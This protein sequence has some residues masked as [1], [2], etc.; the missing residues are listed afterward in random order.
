MRKILPDMKNRFIIYIVI[1][2]QL[3]LCAS[4]A[5]AQD[6]QAPN[7]GWPVRT[8]ESADHRGR[9]AG[10]PSEYRAPYSNGANVFG[11]AVANTVHRYHAGVDITSDN[12][13]N[14]DVYSIEE[15]DHIVD[16][17]SAGYNSRILINNVIY[18]HV[19]H[20]SSILDGI[21]EV[22]YNDQIGDMNSRAAHL[23][24]QP[25]LPE[26]DG[27]SN[28]LIDRLPNY[29]D[30][31]QPEI[32]NAYFYSNG[33]TKTT[34]SFRQNDQVNY[35]N[36]THTI[37]YDK[38]DLVISTNEERVG[39]NGRDYAQG[40]GNMG[41]NQL[42]YEI[43]NEY[44]T[45]ET[46]GFVT[47]LD[48]STL[49]SHFSAQ[50]IFGHASTSAQ[51]Y[52]VLTSFVT[53]DEEN[54]PDRFWNSRLRSGQTE[55][56]NLMN[57]E[58]KEA[59]VNLETRYSDGKYNVRFRVRDVDSD[60]ADN[61]LWSNYREE[62]IIIDNF[63]PFIQKVS[64]YSSQN[65]VFYDQ[66]WNWDNSGGTLDFGHNEGNGEIPNVGE[67]IEFAIVTSEPMSEVNISIPSLGV[68][69]VPAT[70]LGLAL[71]NRHWSF[72]LYGNITETGIHEIQITG[73]DYANNELQMDPSQ[74]P[75]RNANGTWSAG[76]APGADTNHS[77]EFFDGTCNTPAG[78]RTNGNCPL[79]ADFIHQMSTNSPLT[80]IFSSLSSPSNEISSW[81]W[82][83]GDGNSSSD[84]NPTHSY[85]SEGTFLVRL[86]V[87][88]GSE[89]DSYSKNITISNDLNPVFSYTP[90]S[91]N[92]PLFVDLNSSASTGIITDRSWI[93]TPSNGWRYD[94][95]NQ[96]SVSPRLEF[97]N[98]GTYRV[99]LRIGDGHEV[100]D[101]PEEII[102]VQTGLDPVANF[103]WNAP[104]YVNGP[105]RF[106]DRSLFPCVSSLNY[107][108]DFGDGQTSSIG[109]PE[110]I[111]SSDGDYNVTLC[112]EDGCGS[113]DCITKTVHVDPVPNLFPRFN[114]NTYTIRK[115][116]SITF[117]DESTPYSNIGAW[118]WWFEE[119]AD[120][121]GRA[122]GAAD[123][124]YGKSG[125]SS[126][127]THQYNK[128]GEYKVALEVAVND[129]VQGP[130]TSAIIKVIDDPEIPYSQKITSQFI[131]KNIKD[132]K[133][134]GDYTAVLAQDNIGPDY[135]NFVFIYKQVGNSLSKVAEIRDQSISDIA[136][137]GETLVTANLFF[138]NKKIAIWEKGAGEW[139]NMTNPT[140]L[141][142]E[143][144]FGNRSSLDIDVSD[145]NVIALT[146]DNNAFI[147]NKNQS[148]GWPVSHSQKIELA[149]GLVGGGVDIAI[150]GNTIIA[151]SN[152]YIN[153][154]RN[155]N[156]WS[157]AATIEPI[158]GNGRWSS[159][160]IL[161]NTFV[162]L[163]SS[164]VN[165]DVFNNP[166]AYVWER[167][168][169]GD[170]QSNQSPN[171]ELGIHLDSDI[172]QTLNGFGNGTV[173]INN[174]NITIS[175]DFKRQG[176]PSAIF[177]Y[178]R[179]SGLWNSTK[180]DYVLEKSN[181][182]MTHSAH[183]NRIVVSDHNTNGV[184]NSTAS[185]SLRVY[186]LESYCR[187]DL[188]NPRSFTLTA[189]NWPKMS[190]GY[191]D[192]GG[193]YFVTN[194]PTKDIIIIE[195]G[196]NVDMEA[197]TIKITEGFHAKRG[198]NI[199]I[200][201]VTCEELSN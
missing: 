43:I 14:D 168:Q 139:S 15:G 178:K 84:P 33:H 101:S 176:D 29:Q 83:F 123:R 57:R 72:R 46:N 146:T 90:S 118:Y 197:N 129:G 106:L 152:G 104:V 97:F 21:T 36:S 68:N 179:Q 65:D 174:S 95:G 199:K 100:V 142:D 35:S 157:I 85:T 148:G 87:F 201:A 154:L 172:S 5:I 128:V 182:N 165:Q 94:E 12:G 158:T 58:N 9:I 130:W 32:L 2:F 105:L 59:R 112:I 79:I 111:F 188:Y 98:A 162:A 70:S 10:N 62:G 74:I 25:S 169:N 61:G 39:A 161:D 185:G 4:I 64:F 48:F 194:P 171:A 31:D 147:I 92:E 160:D 49:P 164:G 131:R 80:A 50:Y 93:V 193:T 34:I 19:E 184:R 99:K 114:A 135:D 53:E 18:W 41:L 67:D 121:T 150:S 30:L 22:S 143:N 183:G 120:Q 153:I 127:I 137:N 141:L 124:F 200:S 51:P 103:D 119:P 44:N 187:N 13:L 91:G 107:S 45:N 75:T 170:W 167:P 140:H 38:I 117:T 138:D 16:F 144:A 60:G 71:H 55:T 145:D 125:Y 88:R 134:S 156:N 122:T 82:T 69:N 175:M 108:W 126:T 42:G 113:Q 177:T 96:T 37:I 23:H 27:T 8:S 7:Y 109:E 132:I 20:L 155:D 11:T 115:G 66:G 26:I 81:Q 186:D 173:S 47:S 198:S 102:R 110:H 77:I 17:E 3:T 63:K 78:G 89:Q 86:T 116:Q 163:Y 52:Y 181:I 6:I 196:A 195:S 149:A 1:S 192:L 24:L 133:M 190:Y 189:G 76:D 56:W 54:R 73:R 151:Q 180:E 40:V 28:Y 136:F 166:I 159:V 191:I